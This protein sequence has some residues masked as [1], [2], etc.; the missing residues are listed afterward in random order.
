MISLSTRTKAQ[1]EIWARGGFPPSVSPRRPAYVCGL[2]SKSSDF[3]ASKLREPVSTRVPPARAVAT[4]MGG[5]LGRMGLAQGRPGA[6]WGQE[7]SRGP[8]PRVTGI[9]LKEADSL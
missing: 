7:E 3:R 2:F 8:G 1:L 5:L 9:L 6:T 4:R